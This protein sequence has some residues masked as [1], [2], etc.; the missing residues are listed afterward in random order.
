MPICRAA[1]EVGVV[2]GS[3]KYLDARGAILCSTWSGSR[4]VRAP[5]GREELGGWADR[6]GG[7]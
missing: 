5:G 7:R 1:L 2:D 3:Q 6:N 4:L